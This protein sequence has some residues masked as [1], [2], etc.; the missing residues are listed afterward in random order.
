MKNLLKSLI[1]GG[2]ISLIAMSSTTLQAQIPATL[3]DV[4]VS[5][6]TTT[7]NHIPTTLLDDVVVNC[8]MI[9]DVNSD[10]PI[11]AIVWDEGVLSRVSHLYFEDGAGNRASF[12]N[13][14][15]TFTGHRPDI[16]LG[17]DVFSP[18]PSANPT[19]RA[20]VIYI[21]SADYIR[22]NFYNLT[23]AGTP[24]FNA[25]LTSSSQLSQ[26]TQ[27]N[28]FNP[29]YHD[30]DPMPHIDMWS[31]ATANIIGT[32]GK[33]YH[34]L[35]EWV[36][37]W[38]E[39]NFQTGLS[40]IFYTSGHINGT[41]YTPIPLQH[42]KTAALF[43]DSS[44]MPD[45]ACGTN[46]VTGE[47]YASFVYRTFNPTTALQVADYN[48]TKDTVTKYWNYRANTALFPR[49]EAMNLFD[50]SNEARWDVV[51]ILGIAPFSNYSAYN[52]NFAT[53]TNIIPLA[54][55]PLLQNVDIKS[56]CV[57]GGHLYVSG[58][59]EIG[60][61]QFTAGFYPWVTQDLYV[62]EIVANNG[63]P[64]SANHYIVNMNPLAPA[65]PSYNLAD[66]SKSFALSTCSN[67]GDYL[68][69]AWYDGQ[70]NGDGTG[71]NIWMK[72]SPN[73]TTMQFRPTA[74]ATVKGSSVALYPNPATT[75][76]H[77]KQASAYKLYNLTG[78]LIKS[79]TVAAHE[80]IPIQELIPG[81]YRIATKEGVNY[82]FI[83]Q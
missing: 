67:T 48:F 29:Q 25:K 21:D 4:W 11:K 53:D 33:A 16:V 20:V 36:A 34:A 77:L 6:V 57:A 26:Y 66:A 62:R 17:N 19:Y 83:K 27:I 12:Q 59:P 73:A 64:A 51:S 60:N 58:A 40:N 47:K 41:N 30:T 22:V 81:V 28:F 72:L 50:P 71:G 61:K 42:T 46:F 9:T 31:E 24:A 15:H 80:P 69:S 74:V 70:D 55:I 5:D 10:L 52:M 39:I 63:T 8:D 38:S 75:A 54:T 2:V 82:S 3:P 13:D 35:Y 56:P 68:L 76:V 1:W 45:V 43:K 49:I 23:N 44:D 18:S 32:N 78:S 79:G 65:P 37:T 7:K 14:E